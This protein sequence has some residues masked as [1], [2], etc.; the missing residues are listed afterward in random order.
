[1]EIAAKGN[2]TG[3]TLIETVVAIF[4]LITGVVSALALAK[5]SFRY[6]DASSKQIFAT[7]LARQSMEAVKNMRDTNWLD[8]TLVDCSAEFSQAAG[9]QYCYNN[10]L[11]KTYVLGSASAGKAGV[12]YAVDYSPATNSWNLAASPLNYILYYDPS[13]GNYSNVKTS[14]AMASIYSRMVNIVQD[15][16]APFNIANNPRLVV[17][18]TVWWYDQHC[19]QTSNPATLLPS[20]KIILQMYLTNWRDY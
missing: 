9:N 18:T 5:Y 11:S 1:M 16:S 15:F 13:T 12:N 20:C 10:W 4:I 19:P 14:G 17:T 7:A 3:Q 6:T 2:Q 8:D